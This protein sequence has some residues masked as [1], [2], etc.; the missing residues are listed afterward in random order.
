MYTMWK[1]ILTI[2]LV[3]LV[4]AV[5]LR[6]VAIVGLPALR[7]VLLLVIR[8]WPTT[9]QWQ[10]ILDL[11]QS[12]FTILAIFVAGAWTYYNYFKGKIYKIEPEVSGSVVTLNDVLHLK[13]TLGVK[14][15]GLSKV[16]IQEATVLEVTAHNAR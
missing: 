5:I 7:K 8:A 14:N 1:R 9:T 10:T 2:L 11:L 16:D 4:I 3:I 13:A 15:V 6:P 12:G